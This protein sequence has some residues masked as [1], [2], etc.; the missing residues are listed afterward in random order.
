MAGAQPTGYRQKILDKCNSDPCFG[1]AY[2]AVF[3]GVCPVSQPDD[4]LN[5]VR[6]VSLAS[7]SSSL[8]PAQC[9]MTK[10]HL[11]K[12]V[13]KAHLEMVEQEL[14]KAVQVSQRHH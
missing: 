5:E 10:S 13:M 6:I 12:S 11:T 8:C 9:L 4:R 3:F 7:L 2:T 1:V 14:P